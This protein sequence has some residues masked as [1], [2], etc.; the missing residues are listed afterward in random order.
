M[1]WFF[2]ILEGY[3]NMSY[4]YGPRYQ[5]LVQQMQQGGATA[6]K[7]AKE[8]RKSRGYMSPVNVSMIEDEDEDSATSLNTK[9]IK[10]F[11]DVRDNNES[12]ISAKKSKLIEGIDTPIT[13]VS[14]SGQSDNLVSFVASF[15]KFSATPYDDF[16]QT[17]IGYGSK[18]TSKDQKL[19]ETE[20]KNLLKRDLANARNIVLKM[21]K[22]S[23]YDW[24]KNQVD[25]LTSFTHN[26]GAG[27][28]RKLT[29]DGTRG[30]EEISDMLLEYKYAGGKVREGLIKRREAELK[31]FNE[32]YT[33]E[34]N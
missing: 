18:A 29:E 33:N 15:E 9:L 4:N 34:D 30:D 13:K 7:A 12:L 2:L 25:A 28:F 32:G 24:S 27:N 21:K 1:G 23:G 14:F 11:K 5:D 26:L 19:T 3:G 6:V 10:R 31:L 22:D 17:S 20:A 8:A 16:K